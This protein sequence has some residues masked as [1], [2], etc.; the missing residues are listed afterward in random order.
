MLV[1]GTK[2]CLLTGSSLCSGSF[3]FGC[4]FLSE[5]PWEASWMV[6]FLNRGRWPRPSVLYQCFVVT[7]AFYCIIRIYCSVLFCLF[8]FFSCCFCTVYKRARRYCHSKEKAN[9]IKSVRWRGLWGG[10]WGGGCFL[11]HFFF[12]IPVHVFLFQRFCLL[13]WVTLWAVPYF[14]FLEILVMFL[15]VLFF[16]VFFLPSPC[17]VVTCPLILGGQDCAVLLCV[18]PCSPPPC[19]PYRSSSLV[20]L[21]RE[22]VK[23][24]PDHFCSLR[25]GTSTFNQQ[26]ELLFHVLAVLRLISKTGKKKEKKNI[27]KER[28]AF[29]NFWR[30]LISPWKYA[31]C[32]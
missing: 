5:L 4:F 21:V 28:K 7:K 8:V 22:R 24:V 3:C 20:L 2:R 23:R 30:K 17:K 14:F 16:F 19:W 25:R 18:H 15:F 10:M 26:G 27:K 1:S 6:G 32:C 12:C 9:C 29:I 11:F 31:Q 13:V